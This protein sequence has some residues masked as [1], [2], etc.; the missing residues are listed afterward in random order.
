MI[1]AYSVLA[2]LAAL[3]AISS[4]GDW[5]EGGYVGQGNYG[6]TRQ[7]FTDPIFYSSGSQYTSSDPAIR[8][9]E[10]SM[11]RYSSRYA[12]L[13]SSTSKSTFQSTIGKG[14]SASASSATAAFGQPI[15]A[16]GN[17][18]LEL[19][20]GS[21]LD[22]DLSQSGAKIFG[23]G[24]VTSK[25]S[26]QWAVASGEVTGSSLNLE[27]VPASGLELYAI[28]MDISRLH[29]PGSYTAFGANAA[30]ITGNVMASRVVAGAS[31]PKHDTAKN[32][33]G[34]LR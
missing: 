9:M 12:T 25:I 8:Q 16:A 28:S 31:W 19:S 2:V 33:I 15:S 29:L 5:L 6:D 14:K 24:I 17:W 26:S 11:D 10:E 1:K 13:G 7:H 22:L 32:A 27:V 4:A 20:D 30:P 21:L 34:N 23:R 3:T 18:H